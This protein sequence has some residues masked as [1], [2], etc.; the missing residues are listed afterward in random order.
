MKLQIL[1]ILTFFIS[2][3]KKTKR[4][5]LDNYEWNKVK[6]SRNYNDFSRY[7]TKHPN[8]KYFITAIKKNIS[9]RDSLNQTDSYIWFCGRTN[10]EINQINSD[11]ILFNGYLINIEKL[12]DSTYNYLISKRVNSYSQ[13]RRKISGIEKKIKLSSG[14]IDFCVEKEF[15]SKNIYQKS[16]QE[17]SKGLDKYKTYVIEKILKVKESELNQIQ[18]EE[19]DIL[20]SEKLSFHKFVMRLP[21]I[22]PLPPDN[23][24]SN[25]NSP[26]E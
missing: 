2:C 20:I 26:I 10:V 15:L 6:L 18:K 16:V 5:N 8:S 25:E 12:K 9:L 22:P 1:I 19:L 7:A 4:E 11:S 23:Y 24:E 3:C 14:Y 21:P 13:I 17:I